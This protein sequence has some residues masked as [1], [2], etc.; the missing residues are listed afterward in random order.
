MVLFCLVLSVVS[1]TGCVRFLESF[2]QVDLTPW[3]SAELE[4]P[5]DLSQFP[6]FDLPND[7]HTGLVMFTESIGRNSEIT[8]ETINYETWDSVSE[9]ITFDR[10]FG[11]NDKVAFSPNNYLWAYEL[12][13]HNDP[14]TSFENLSV[15]DSKG[16]RIRQIHYNCDMVDLLF[17][18]Q[19][20]YYT[21]LTEPRIFVVDV[22]TLTAVTAIEVGEEVFTVGHLGVNNGRL[23]A[24]AS[25][26]SDDNFYLV[27]VDLMTDQVLT[28]SDPTEKFSMYHFDRNAMYQDQLVYFNS[29][30]FYGEPEYEDVMIDNKY[31]LVDFSDDI[32]VINYLSGPREG[33]LNTVLGDSIFSTYSESYFDENGDL[34][35]TENFLVEK[36]ILTDEM[37]QWEWP[38]R[39]PC[40]ETFFTHE[41]EI[42]ILGSVTTDLIISDP[43]REV[44]QQY[45]EEGPTFCPDEWVRGIFRFD[46]QT[47]MFEQV[48]EMPDHAQQRTFFDVYETDN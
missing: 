3:P 44:V 7:D 2:F 15:F 48:W 10:P 45:N 43:P 39:M 33:H 36:N 40:F 28:I 21:C 23:I 8:I 37:T 26:H 14:K 34:D 35:R 6:P 24:T 32:P 20:A 25:K 47:G 5:I 22:E 16:N 29:D 12:K 1:S 9:E 41:Q 13:N 31:A 17:H 42:Y 46:R 4:T 11:H 27:Q 18:E 19:K 38:S 30:T